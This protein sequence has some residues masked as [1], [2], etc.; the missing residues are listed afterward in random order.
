MENENGYLLPDPSTG[1]VLA[2]DSYICGG[3]VSSTAIFETA[4]DMQYMYGA[5]LEFNS[6]VSLFSS[7]DLAYVDMSTDGGA[8]WSS[9]WQPDGLNRNEHVSVILFDQNGIIRYHLY[10]SGKILSVDART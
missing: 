5:T 4:Q 1:K 10:C 9:V 3:G 6:D 8:T 7:A 2:A